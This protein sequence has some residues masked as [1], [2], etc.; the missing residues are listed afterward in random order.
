MTQRTLL[1]VDDDSCILTALRMLFEGDHLVSTAEMGADALR[2]LHEKT[3]DVILLDVSL[4][5]MNGI[6]LLDEIK[7]LAP[8]TAVIMMTAVE[9]T[10]L[11]NRARE[12][13][14]VDYLVKPIDAKALKA[15]LQNG[16]QRRG[17]N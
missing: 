16:F 7:S 3:P 2:I 12:L 6:D 11:I 9:E 14:A 15:A 4:P 10:D 17:R 8:A 1:I 13:G 5:D